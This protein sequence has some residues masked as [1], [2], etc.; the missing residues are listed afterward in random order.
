MEN[1]YT[2][3]SSTFAGNTPHIIESST[4]VSFSPLLAIYCPLPGRKEPSS[5]QN[6]AEVLSSLSLDAEYL[7]STSPYD[8]D[9]Y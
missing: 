2:R 4:I 7:G 3:N 8:D 6:D 5:Q 9:G 1:S